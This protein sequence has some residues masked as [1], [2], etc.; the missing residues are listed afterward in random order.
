MLNDV[1]ALLATLAMGAFAWFSFKMVAEEAYIDVED[2][3]KHKVFAYVEKHGDSYY[4][5]NF[6][7]NTFIMQFKSLVEF[8]GYI[9]QHF[10][11]KTFII[12]GE[13]PAE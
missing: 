5:Y 11:G 6:D 13:M 4:I 7:T 2:P 9:N 12:K 3:N 1:V 8:A 10:P